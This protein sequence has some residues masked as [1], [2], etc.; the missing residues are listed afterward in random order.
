M[1]QVALMLCILKKTGKLRTVI[2]CRKC[3]DNTVKD[4]TPFPD[5]D[6]IRMD[7]TRAKYHSKIGLL[8]A[9]K[10]VRC[11][12]PNMFGTVNMEH[13]VDSRLSWSER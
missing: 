11:H 13:T 1:P 5:Q 9:Y 3:N 6:Q 2:D 12:T 7:V 4:I 8:N 10:Q